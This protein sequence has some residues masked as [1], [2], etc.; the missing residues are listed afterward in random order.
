MVLINKKGH[1]CY[2]YLSI[3]TPT[4]C[5]GHHFFIVGIAILR[6]NGYVIV[7]AICYRTLMQAFLPLT[8]KVP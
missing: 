8:D 1:Y 2:F 4:C 5:L 7:K 3:S 6:D